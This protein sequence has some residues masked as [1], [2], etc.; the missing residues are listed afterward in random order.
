VI[1][2][3]ASAELL[4]RIVTPT[5]ELRRAVEAAAAPGVEIRFG[6]EIPL[7]KGGTAPP[8][9]QTT[10]VSFTSDLPF[11]APWGQA[12]QLGPGSIRVA[13]TNAEHIRK[14][15]LMRGVELYVR[16][17]TDLLAGTAA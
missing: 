9:W 8:G 11:L 16:L 5:A 12:Y 3:E 13:H 10:V 2:A 4:F 7:H 1:P 6:L 17:A 14:D 15:D